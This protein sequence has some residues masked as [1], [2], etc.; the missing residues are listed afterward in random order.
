VLAWG[1]MLKGA[2]ASPAGKT[3]LWVL[4]KVG[5]TAV[6]ERA[7][8]AVENGVGRIAD[9]QKAIRKARHTIE[10]RWAPVIVEDRTRWVVYSGSSPIEIFP[11]ITGD[12]ATAM[13]TFDVARLRGPDDVPTARSRAWAKS[14]LAR[15]MHRH[16]GHT[17]ETIP[18][19]QIEAVSDAP[20]ASG[21]EGGQALLHKVV[22]DL[23]DLLNRLS[24]APAKTVAE[25]EEIPATPGVYLFSEGVTPIYVGQTENLR[26]RLRQQ[27]SPSSRENHASLAW[28]IAL[29]AAQDARHP[30]SGTS[31]KLEPDEQAEMFRSAKRR[32]AAMT[33]RFI[34]LA[35]PVTRAVFEIYAARALGTDEFTP[36]ETS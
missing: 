18:S 30:V 3:A 32:V 20:T 22:D 10:G 12:L 8:K 6:V 35:D 28:R 16:G 34:E 33:V 26:D 11:A 19:A 13:Q 25:H 24:S 7:L 1:V 21:E 17:D 14:Q 9:R 2:L 4:D 15:M 31:K 23:P 5:L 29:A 36:G 27:T